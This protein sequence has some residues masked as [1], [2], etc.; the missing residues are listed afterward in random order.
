MDSRH[1]DKSL[2]CLLAVLMGWAGIHRFYLHGK[3]DIGGWAYVLASA[4]YV[5][6]GAI[7][8]QTGAVNAMVI[9]WLPLLFFCQ[10]LKRLFMA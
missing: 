7:G 10:C 6:C 2:T 8:I 5:A 4:L 1:K 3:R 9:V